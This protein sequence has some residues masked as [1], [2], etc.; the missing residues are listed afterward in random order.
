[1]LEIPFVGLVQRDESLDVAFVEVVVHG[2]VVMGTVSMEA[3]KE[4]FIIKEL[5]FSK[6]YDRGDAVMT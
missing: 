2:I 6:R 5:G 3:F 1:M 4:V